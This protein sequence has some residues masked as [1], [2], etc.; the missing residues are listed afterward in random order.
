[1]R[2]YLSG[3]GGIGLSAYA[4]HMHFRGH[5]IWGSDRADS[6]LI[7]ALQTQGMFITLDQKN[8]E[9]PEDI[10][11]FVY[12]E[13]IPAD[14][15]ERKEATRRGI[16][17][18]SYFQALG[19]LTAGKN[20]IAICGT[21]GKSST[22]AMTAVTFEQLGEDPNVV[23][24]TKVPDL[25]G[26]NWRASEK[27]L[28]IVEACE[29]RRSFLHL[30]PAIILLTNA[31]GDHFDSFKNIEDYQQAFV[32]F[33]SQLP[34]NG[35]VIGHGS[36]KATQD[37]IKK[38][39]ATFIDADSISL[40]ALTVPGVHMQK[41]AQLVLALAKHLA[42]KEKPVLTALKKFSGSWRR[43]EE[44]GTVHGITVIDDYAHHPIEIMATLSAM[45][46]AYPNRRIVGVF[47]PHTHDRTRQ[48]W[49]QFAPAF[50]DA[51]TMLLA[52]IY[53]ARPDIENGL[54]DE[55]AFAEAIQKGSKKPC[56]FSGS[57]QKTEEMLRTKILKEGDVL[58]IMGAGDSTS[59][60]DA[61]MQ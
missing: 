2:L 29:Y 13:A 30:K 27:D 26:Q 16:R 6:E 19:E 28:W 38:T 33:V 54:V 3:I 7:Q 52:S 20:L 17:Q 23:V 11:L 25:A 12:S 58:V 18:I 55:V 24:G 56:I 49:D 53:D 43:M 59:L 60:A 14:A 44:K 51:D 1:M 47:Q 5:S 46:G 34:K 31:D 15:P 48:F 4:S 42:L 41:N 39:K 22:T 37:I 40:P 35:I 36:D 57:L 10:D 9:L 61:M 32:E 21:H 45:R 50:R 8:G